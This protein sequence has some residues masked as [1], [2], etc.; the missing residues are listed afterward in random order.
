MNQQEC[1]W[2][3]KKP[4]GQVDIGFQ[5]TYISEHL[6]EAFHILPASHGKIESGAPMMVVESNDGLENIHSPFVGRFVNFSDKARN[7]PDRLKETDVVLTLWT[8]E[9]YQN[10][11]KKSKTEVKKKAPVK[12]T[13]SQVVTEW[14]DDV[15]AA[16]AQWDI[17]N[18]AAF[19]LPPDVNQQNMA[20][21]DQAFFPV[22]PARPADVPAPARHVPAPAARAP[23]RRGIR[24]GE[25]EGDFVWNTEQ[26]LQ[27]RNL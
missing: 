18:R 23:A 13:P 27:F 12:N 17:V 7:F 5:Q 19:N 8:E 15:E 26:W 16:G 9:A 3:N 20:R 22:Q 14:F 24:Y 21:F 10:E 11:L 4:N 2:M 6:Q 1:I 25:I